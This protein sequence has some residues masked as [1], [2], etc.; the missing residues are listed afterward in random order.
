MTDETTPNPRPDDPGTPHFDESA[1]TFHAG[2]ATAGVPPIGDA[3]ARDASPLEPEREP[4][5][6]PN[7]QW[8]VPDDELEAD[9]EPA[10]PRA[11][12]PILAVGSVHPLIPELCA[13]LAQLGYDTPTARGENPHCVV[14]PEELAAARQFRRDHDVED[15]PDAFGHDEATNH[16]GPWTI[17]AILD[18]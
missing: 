11:G 17:E 14:G 9:D 2:E 18:A 5:N 4:F 12:L 1:Q 8:A 16:I 7:T 6:T 15:D 3:A 10:G 13:K